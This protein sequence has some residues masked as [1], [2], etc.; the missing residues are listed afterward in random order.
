MREPLIIAFACLLLW[1]FVGQSCA[2]DTNV[3]KSQVASEWVSL[4]NGNDLS[5][6]R[7]IN[8]FATFT[9]EEGAIVGTTVDNSPNSFLCTQ[10][11]FGDFDLEFE[12]K[13]D[14]NLN[15]GVQVRSHSLNSYRNGNVFGYQVEVAENGNAGFIYDE[16]RRGWLSLDRSDPQKRAVY[17]TGVWNA[18]RV[19][20]QGDRIITWVNGVPVDNLQDGMDRAGFIGLQVHSFGMP[21]DDPN[22][23]PLQGGKNPSHV[24]WRNLRIRVLD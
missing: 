24:R 5:G 15:S 14:P 1:T 13:L 8:G 17:K 22:R 7:Q 19:V 18:Y 3:R 12:V 16:E 21:N 11:N 9:V 20:C 2:D 4:F 10:H 6:W 23:S